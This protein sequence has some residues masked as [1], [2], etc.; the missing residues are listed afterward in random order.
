LKKS[1][2]RKRLF[3][4]HIKEK[5]AAQRGGGIEEQKNTTGGK[6]SPGSVQKKEK[7]GVRKRSHSG[8]EAKE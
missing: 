7:E 3:Y 5:H 6:E 8:M 1:P 4:E 2:S